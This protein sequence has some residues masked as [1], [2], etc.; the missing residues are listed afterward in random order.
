MKKKIEFK[1]EEELFNSYK[2]FCEINGY[3]MSKRLRLFIESEIPIKYNTI[4]VNDIKR[5]PI[6]GFSLIEI[7]GKKFFSHNS[8]AKVFIISTSDV[9]S[10]NI[11]FFNNGKKY[12]LKGVEVHK[13]EDG[14]FLLECKY[15]KV[16][17]QD[18]I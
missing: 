9:I 2:E 10:E 4:I 18:F 3:D 17:Y 16:I 6:F 8:D 14:Y 13:E 11:N 1:L 7:M 12:E 5:E 15:F